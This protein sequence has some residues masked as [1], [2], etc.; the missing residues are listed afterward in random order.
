[1]R[2]SP[3]L[4]AH[5]IVL[6]VILGA[7]A[8]LW[9]AESSGEQPRE[10]AAPSPPTASVPAA[11]I[12]PE[13]ERAWDDPIRGRMIFDAQ[14]WTSTRTFVNIGFTGTLWAL[15]PGP[16]AHSLGAGLF[17]G[18]S[19]GMT[20]PGS[21]THFVLAVPELGVKAGTPRFHLAAS[22]GVAV[23]GDVRDLAHGSYGLR[24]RVVLAWQ[25]LRHLGFFAGL[26][27]LQ[28]FGL[29]QGDPASYEGILGVQL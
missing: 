20:G 24:T 23:D 22:W 17:V 13:S 21:A 19:G 10:P 7:H 4:A 18:M 9:A 3:R 12:V 15:P 16:G 6:A 27:G 2:S 14:A 5:G 29:T 1:M 28:R 26:G 8:R 11:A 25:P